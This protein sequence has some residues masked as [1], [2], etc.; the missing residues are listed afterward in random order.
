MSDYKTPKDKLID[1]KQAANLSNA[2]KEQRLSVIESKLGISDHASFWYSLEDLEGYINY[3]KEQAKSKGITLD[4][5]RIYLGVYPEGYADSSKSGHAT[6]FMCPTEAARN[7]NSCDV[8]G[9]SAFN[10]GEVGD[11]PQLTY[12]G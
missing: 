2:Y 5:M 4:G 8:E 6:V 1:A 9:I 10:Y 3:A 12:G 11:P 7:Q